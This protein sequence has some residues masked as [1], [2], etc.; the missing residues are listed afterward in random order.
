MA[1]T[2]AI[3]VLWKYLG[4]F[5]LKTVADQGCHRL[6][7]VIYASRASSMRTAITISPTTNGAVDSLGPRRLG[8]AGRDL[9][10]AVQRLMRILRL[11]AAAWEWDGD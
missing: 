3:K 10:W 11:L 7:D 5:R 8:K 1:M 6:E 4:T 9:G 2:K